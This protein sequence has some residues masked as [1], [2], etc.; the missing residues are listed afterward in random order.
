MASNFPGGNDAIPDIVNPTVTL[1]NAPPTLSTRVNTTNDG[2]VAVQN[3]LNN[4]VVSVAFSPVTQPQSVDCG[5]A[6]SVSVLMSV[7]SNFNPS[8]SL[9]NLAPG[10]PVAMRFINAFTSS[11]IFTV[12]P[13]LPGGSTYQAIAKGPGGTI[14]IL[15]GGILIAPGTTSM[16][17][18]ASSTS[19][20]LNFIV[21]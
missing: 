18:Y 10:I 20:F 15:N 3:W 16:F 21:S 17:S 5:N 19:S 14:F 7:N 12:I 4:A 2:L 6:I 13:S 11:L 9:I 1:R 8:L